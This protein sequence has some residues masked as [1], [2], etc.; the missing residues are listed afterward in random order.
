MKHLIILGT[1]GFSIDVCEFA[2][3]SIG[4]GKEFVIKGFMDRDSLILDSYKTKYKFLGYE[5]DYEILPDDVFVCAIGQ[6]EIRENCINKL[7]S[8]G[9]HFINII[10]NSSYISP[11]SKMGEGNIFL[12]NTQ[13]GAG[14]TIGNFNL[15]Q[16]NT[17]IAHDCCIGDF[18]RLD[19]NVMCVG[20]IKI[21]NGTIIHTGAVINHKV[22][23]ENDAVVG[24]N[25]FVIRKVKESTTVWGNPAKKL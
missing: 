7:K 23:I 19:C 15:F 12:P 5:D 18:N 10:H 6:K 2:K 25:S 16:T 11:T 17:I 4:Y 13:L 21:G 22:C 1:S 3:Q 24:A 9:A 20:G 8:R 14:A